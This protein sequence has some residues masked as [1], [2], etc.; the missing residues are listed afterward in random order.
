MKTFTFNLDRI[1]LI[2]LFAS[3]MFSCKNKAEQNE[4]AQ[5]I[6][7]SM[8]EQ[9]VVQDTL[10]PV[11]N[12]SPHTDYQPAFK[13]Q[14]RVA[15]METQT[16]FEVEVLT[17][18][19]QKPWGI[20]SLPEGGFLITQKEGDMVWVDEKGNIQQTVTGFP[21][22]NSAGQGGLL[23]LTLDPNFEDNQMLYWVFSDAVSNGNL[24]AVGKGKLN[25]E[26]GTIENPEVIY[27]AEPAYNGTL[28]YGGRIVFD[29]EGNLFVST[30]ERSDLVTRPQ[31]QELGSALGKVL[32]MTKD[33]KPVKDHPFQKDGQFPEIYSYGHRNV[34]GLAIHPVTGDLW[35]SEMGP[36]GGDEINRIQSGKNYGWPTITYGL[37]Y[38]GEKIGEAITQKSGMEQPVY[39]WDPSISPSGIT[40]YAGKNIPEWENDLFVGCLSGSHIIRLKIRNDKVVG[41]ERLLEKENQ[42]FRDLTQG[43]DGNLYAITDQGRLY[44]IYRK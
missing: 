41:E 10:P 5:Q 12:E 3:L 37:E 20:V 38:S 44:K 9:S 35:E 26:E 17:S 14:T 27:R 30:G 11:E 29:R 23:G 22:V 32:R 6:N 33:G 24:T 1:V 18:S 4:M 19:L 40:F 15:G 43:K 31:A 36:M 34:Q 39:Y 16:D 21:K 28:H 13:G 8:P 42:R 25:L 7:D 2:F